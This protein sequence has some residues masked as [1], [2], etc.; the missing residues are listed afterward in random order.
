MKYLEMKKL[1]NIMI[2]I[3]VIFKTPMI[4]ENG[5]LKPITKEYLKELL[6]SESIMLCQPYL[7]LLNFSVLKFKLYCLSTDF[8]TFKNDLF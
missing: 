1:A 8:L 6:E 4:G 7:F 3:G 5:K 2:L